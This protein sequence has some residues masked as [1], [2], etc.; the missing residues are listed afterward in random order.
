MRRISIGTSNGPGL[1]WKG[2]ST[3]TEK[4]S[5]LKELDVEQVNEALGMGMGVERHPNA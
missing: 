2:L 4:G 5:L 3:W 1:W